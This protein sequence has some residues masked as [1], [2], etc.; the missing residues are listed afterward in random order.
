MT[1]TEKLNLN[2]I[3]SISPSVRATTAGIKT[4]NNMK[5]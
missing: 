1:V 5:N 2:L 3:N 4:N